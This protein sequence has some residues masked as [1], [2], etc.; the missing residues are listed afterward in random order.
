MQIVLGLID[1]IKQYCIK[2]RNVYCIRI[3]RNLIPKTS[4][5]NNQ[6]DFHLYQLERDIIEPHNNKTYKG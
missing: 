1:K 3:V 5:R 2:K 6:L 4:L